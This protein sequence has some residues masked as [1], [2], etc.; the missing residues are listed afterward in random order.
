MKKAPTFK[1]IC[2]VNVVFLLIAVTAYAQRSAIE[3]AYKEQYEIYSSEI[4]DLKKSISSDKAYLEIAKSAFEY[5]YDPNTVTWKKKKTL[6]MDQYLTLQ[7]TV[8]SIEKK[9]GRLKELEGKK[10]ELKIKI[11]EKRGSLPSWWAD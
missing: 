10:G 4:A 6:R 7:K 2:F 9:Q 11:L 5:E 3:K 8:H 1:I